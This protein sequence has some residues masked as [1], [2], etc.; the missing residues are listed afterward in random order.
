[1]LKAE[2]MDLTVLILAKHEAENLQRLLPAVHRVLEGRGLVY[3]ILVVTD[4]SDTETGEV[5]RR[6]G[7]RVMAQQGPGYGS[8]FREGMAGTSGRF[9]AAIDADLS[10]D[11]EV[12]V[13]L[14]AAKEDAGLVIA[15]RYTRGGRATMPLSRQVLSRLLNAMVRHGLSLHVRDVSSGFRL[16]RREAVNAAAL[17]ARHFDILEE[18]LIHILAA[19]WTVKEIPFHYQPRVHG[20]SKARLLVFG[21]SFLRSFIRMRQ[22]RHSAAA[23]R[24]A[25]STTDVPAQELRERNR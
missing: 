7:A 13:Q 3:D 6:C 18:V 10:H 12:I 2:L 25:R 14:W 4:P 1:M 5:S 22:L 8:A 16:Y 23:P 20:R 15:S 24:S 19:G 17:R 11:P 9:V 21:W